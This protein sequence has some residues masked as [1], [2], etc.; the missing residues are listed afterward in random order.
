[1]R[2]LIYAIVFT[3][4][5]VVQLFVAARPL[6]TGNAARVPFRGKERLAALEAIR[7]NR[8]PETEAAYLTELRL[9]SRYETRKKLPKCAATLAAFLFFDAVWLYAYWRARH[10]EKAAA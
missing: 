2:T 3:V 9:A 4:V 5:L 10:D 1:M 6:M 7:T 8:S